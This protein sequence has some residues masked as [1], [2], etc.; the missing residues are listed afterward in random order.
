MTR[1]PCVCPA[2][3]S[4]EIVDAI[5]K[6]RGSRGL[7]ELDG[8]LLNNQEIAGGFN[9]LMDAVRSKTSLSADLREL[10][11]LRVAALNKASYEWKAHE[12]IGRTGGLTTTELVVIRDVPTAASENINTH[13]LSPLKAA[14]LIYTDYLTLH[15]RVPD[16]VFNKLRSKLTNDQQMLEVTATISA[17]NFVSRI[18]VSM[19]VMGSARAEV[20]TVDANA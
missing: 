17:Y 15:V 4:S 7:I 6:R 8:I 1:I 10:L 16:A 9:S 5:I 12:P 11:I 3:G 19:D 2:A 20:P 13:P 14:A 18:L